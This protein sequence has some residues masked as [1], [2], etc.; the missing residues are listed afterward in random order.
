[1]LKALRAR[2]RARRAGPRS[3]STTARTSGAWPATATG[4]SRF[5][6]SAAVTAKLQ[7][8]LHALR[9][10]R[11]H[12]GGVPHRRRHDRHD[13]GA[14]RRP[15]G[16]P[17]PLLVCKR[18]ADGR[19]RLPRRDPRQPRRRRSRP[20]LPDRGVQR[21]RRRR[22]LHV[23]P[24]A[25]LAARRAAGR[26][27]LQL[28][29]R[30]RRLR[31]LAPRLH[32]GLSRPGTELQFFL[33]R[34]V[35]RPAAA[36]GRRARADPLGDQPAC[37]TG[38]RC[39]SSPSTTASSSRTMAGADA[40]AQIGAFKHL[41]LAG[42][43]SRSPAA[44][45]ATASCCDG[46]LG[47]DA[48]DAAAGTGL[49]IGRPIEMPGVAPLA[50]SSSSARRRL[51][52]APNG[53]SSQVVKVLCFYHPDDA[54]DMR[55]RAGATAAPPV[56]RLPR[57]PPRVAARD[58]PLQGRPGRRRHHRARSSSAS[59]IS[60]SIPTGGSWSRCRP[61]PPGRNAVR[62]DRRAT[63]RYCRGIVVLGPRRAEP[64]AAGR[65]FAAAAAVA[66]GQ[67]LRGRP[68]DL[69]RGRPRLA[70]RR[71]RRRRGRRRAWP[72]N[73][74]RLCRRL[75][76][77][78]AHAGRAEG[79]RSM[80]TIRL[81]AA[82]ALVRWLRRAARHEE[83]RPLLRRRLGDLR[84]RQRRRH[85]RGA[86]RRRATTLPTWRAPQRAGAWP[87]PPSPTPRPMRRRRAMAV[88]HLDRPRRAPTW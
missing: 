77:R 53:R 23:R 12:R 43:P 46:R 86:A 33:E 59:T 57:Q 52:A 41:C 10:D 67:G 83:R 19:R 15:R 26:R 11:R 61:R 73:Y 4:E 40:R 9:P 64:R 24:P 69:R 20:G 56:R 47:R 6:D 42:R 87:M 72:A 21:A 29:Q 27:A 60:A 85:R 32:A 25:R 31:R 79:S 14:A 48:L 45:P 71:D 49:W 66:A 76:R 2:P 39:G 30:L 17:T 7:A 62:G 35:K 37:A 3:T 34:G 82:Q 88:H 5:V 80:T 75:G 54:P 51:G 38:R 28:R 78:P 50:W 55:G 63:T 16:A 68:H 58:H 1:M 22:R 13:R 36:Q 65:S 70:G 8:T 84:P 74:E 44:D 18:G 81:T